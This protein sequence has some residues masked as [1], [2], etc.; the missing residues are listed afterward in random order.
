LKFKP[1][2]SLDQ[3][4]RHHRINGSSAVPKSKTKSKGKQSKKSSDRRWN[5]IALLVVTAIVI[6]L[7]YSWWQSST[8]ETSFIKLAAEG[9][10][11]G[12]KIKTFPSQ[13][14]RHL[15]PGQPYN[16][17]DPYPTSGPHDP[18]WV[19]PGFYS[20]PQPPTKLVHALEHGNVVIYYDKPD[21][22]VFET[23]Q[24]W[25]SIY[26]GQWDG[27]V[28]TK[29][30]GIGDTIVLTAWTKK[31]TLEKF[32]APTA[33]AFIDLFRGRGPENPMR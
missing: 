4:T 21:E 7:G 2:I 32:D 28:V 5:I 15:T 27:I 1:K 23:L 18:T 16:Y 25:A 8:T 22:K 9:K 30:N 29:K 24:S 14:Q 20:S 12:S 11:V 13:G 33:A 19:Q 31:L 3:Y 10:S 26:P 6:T 17:P